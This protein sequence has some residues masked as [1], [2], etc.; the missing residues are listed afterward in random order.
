MDNPDS[1]LLV[2]E[3]EVVAR[4]QRRRRRE[5]TLGLTTGSMQL[6]ARHRHAWGSRSNTIGATTVQACLVVRQVAVEQMD[7]FCPITG[8]L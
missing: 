2:L 5:G 7:M 3:A 6:K 1:T 8:Q 4:S